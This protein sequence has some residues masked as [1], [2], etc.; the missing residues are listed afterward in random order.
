MGASSKK[1]P[2]GRYS[3]SAAVELLKAAKLL[4]E[5]GVIRA[6]NFHIRRT[7]LVLIALLL[8]WMAI[9]DGA[10][11]IMDWASGGNATV[12]PALF[13]HIVCPGPVSLWAAFGAAIC[14]GMA[15]RRE[16]SRA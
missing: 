7:L 9:L 15:G 1:F 13:G 5:G 12:Q 8:C 14:I 16:R 10:F 4:A 3:R 11:A 6:F 2:P